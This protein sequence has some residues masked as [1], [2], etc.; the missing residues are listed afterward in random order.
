MKRST[1]K[2]PRIDPAV[3]R[4]VTGMRGGA[5]EIAAAGP[6]SRAYVCKVVNGLKPPSMRFLLALDSVLSGAKRR[7]NG[8]IIRRV[9]PEVDEVSR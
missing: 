9:H 6:F 7:V 1:K 8:A 4:L 3:A 2:R 5:A